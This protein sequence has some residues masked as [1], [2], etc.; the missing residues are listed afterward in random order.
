MEK[1]YHFFVKILSKHWL[2]ALIL[3][4]SMLV[5]IFILVITFENVTVD[6]PLFLSFEYES[7]H[8]YVVDTDFSDISEPFEYLESIEGRDVTF[9]LL[10][11]S[12]SGESIYVFVG[13]LPVLD[14]AWADIH[15]PVA[16]IPEPATVNEFQYRGR[17]LPAI[18]MDTEDL[19]AQ[20][21]YHPGNQKPTII[22]DPGGSFRSWIRSE[23]P[24]T[25]DELLLG[26]RIKATNTPLIDDIVAAS[27]RWPLELRAAQWEG[28][29][30]KGFLL[31]NQYPLILLSLLFIMVCLYLIGYGMIAEMRLHMTLHI[32]YG[33]HARS[34]QIQAQLIVG[35]II[36]LSLLANRQVFRIM[37]SDETAIR[38]LSM[39]S[40]FYHLITGLGMAVTIYAV[41]RR[42][43]VNTTLRADAMAKKLN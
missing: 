5:S 28:L 41:S 20:L 18:P 6:S 38:Q 2:T 16:F 21:P 30:E 40:T 10:E 22:M 33:A 19:F 43:K 4:S 1:N 34:L 23:S 25:L 26:L 11:I 8:V 37:R 3:C 9:S 15:E 12:S 14:S 24:W 36:V 39:L 35:L 42:W 27:K 13:D 31:L 17:S 7:F 32:I 29:T